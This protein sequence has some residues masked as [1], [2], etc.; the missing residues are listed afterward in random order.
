[1]ALFNKPRIIEFVPTSHLP[2]RPLTGCLAASSTWHIIT[3]CVRHHLAPNTTLQIELVQFI[4]I[5][6]FAGVCVTASVHTTT[7]Y[8]ELFADWRA[9]V[10]IAPMRPEIACRLYKRPR[11]CQKIVFLYVVAKFLYLLIW[12]H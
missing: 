3:A 6:R 11:A 7:E 2:R 5:K 8:I 4:A 1:M 9:R 12:K 10:K